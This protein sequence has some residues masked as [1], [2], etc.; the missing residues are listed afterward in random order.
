MNEKT[1]SPHPLIAII[2]VVVLIVFLGI[3][4][5]LFG[6][7]SL[8]GGSQIALLMGMSVCVCLSMAINKVRWR[9]FEEQIKTTIGGVAATLLILLCVGMLSGSWMISGIV[10]TLIYYGI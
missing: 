2:P 6:S 1:I 3:V 9:A 4:I 7:D 5:A 8:N 10:P